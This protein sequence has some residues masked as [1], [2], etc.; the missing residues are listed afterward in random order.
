M[1]E[2]LAE[3]LRFVGY[4]FV[5]AGLFIVVCFTLDSFCVRFRHWKSQRPQ[6]DDEFRQYWTSRA[7]YHQEEAAKIRKSLGLPEVTR[8][9]AQI[10]RDLAEDL[11]ELK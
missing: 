1:S 8:S 10:S 5:S 2:T 4:F 6:T 11:K 7:V 3:G 9:A